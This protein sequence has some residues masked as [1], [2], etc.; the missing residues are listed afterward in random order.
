MPDLIDYVSSLAL[1]PE[2][3]G[4]GVSVSDDIRRPLVKVV[5]DTVAGITVH[6]IA[7]VSRTLH[8]DDGFAREVGSDDYRLEVTSPGVEAGLQEPWQFTRHVGRRL[9]V[10]LQSTQDLH[11]ERIKGQLLQSGPEGIVLESEAGETKIP[12]SR[13][14]KAVVQ[15]DW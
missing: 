11:P 4:L 9:A 15:L 2:V 3:H 14:Q 6:E 7:Y 12:W 5:V 1:G 8:R 10:Q 13:I